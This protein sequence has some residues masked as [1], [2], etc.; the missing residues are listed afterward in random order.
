[1]KRSSLMDF[2]FKKKPDADQTA[3]SP[4]RQKDE[5]EQPAA[6]CDK[7]NPMIQAIVKTGALFFYKQHSFFSSLRCCL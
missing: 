7:Q 3:S 1:M 5:S 4:K 6:V 2:G